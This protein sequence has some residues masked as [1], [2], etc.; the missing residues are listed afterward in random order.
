MQFL[1]GAIRKCR[2]ICSRP[3]LS[4]HLAEE[5]SPGMERT[6]DQELIEEIKLRAGTVY[7]PV[8]TCKMGVDEMAVVG[9]DLRVR[10]IE[11][12]RVVD[13]SIKPTITG[14]NTNAPSMM[15]GDRAA[16]LI[17]EG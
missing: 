2:Q 10:G 9:P 1:L 5:L 3:E 7:H 13:A 14:S 6:T 8:G 4:E 16:A 12:L 15:I 11:G 17:Q